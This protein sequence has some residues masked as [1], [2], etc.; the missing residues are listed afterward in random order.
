MYIIGQLQSQAPPVVNWYKVFCNCFLSF[1]SSFLYQD[2]DERVAC[3]TNL[4]FALFRVTVSMLQRCSM[5]KLTCNTQITQLLGSASE[6]IDRYSHADIDALLLLLLEVFAI[7]SLSVFSLSMNLVMMS[8]YR[9]RALF[10]S[11][12]VVR[13]WVWIHQCNNDNLINWPEQ[14]TQ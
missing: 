7:W 13:C 3:T 1:R 11:S 5:D 4:E 10:T 2:D 14:H 8:V 6:G 12:F 9:V